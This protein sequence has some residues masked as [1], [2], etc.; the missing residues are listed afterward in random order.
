MAHY[1]MCFIN[2]GAMTAD[3]TYA[4]SHTNRYNL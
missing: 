3:Q 4:H 1:S 2:L